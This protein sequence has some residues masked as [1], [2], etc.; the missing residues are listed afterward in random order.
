M[1]VRI[2]AVSLGLLSAGCTL[3]PPLCTRSTGYWTGKVT[4]AELDIELFLELAVWEALGGYEAK[5]ILSHRNT[6]IIGGPPGTEDMD[7]W[8][9]PSDFE[10]ISGSECEDPSLPPLTF[11]PRITSLID[12]STQLTSTIR[13]PL[14][15]DEDYIEGQSTWMLNTHSSGSPSRPPT[16]SPGEPSPGRPA[17]VVA[18]L[19]AF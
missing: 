2:W 19:L 8:T 6:V 3:Q 15:L 18:S 9:D 7:D 12:G 10:F 1:Y 17:T 13:I 14:Q 11:S 4:S 5:G 16:G